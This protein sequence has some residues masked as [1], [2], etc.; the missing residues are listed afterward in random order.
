M[1]TNH[2]LIAKPNKKQDVFHIVRMYV[3]GWLFLTVVIP[4]MG[5]WV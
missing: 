5:Y 4:F 1:I 2:G 3:I